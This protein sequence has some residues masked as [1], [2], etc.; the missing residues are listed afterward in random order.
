MDHKSSRS[1]HDGGDSLRVPPLQVDKIS[2]EL[3]K[4]ETWLAQENQ[5]LNS[6]I[7]VESLKNIVSN[8]E[9][10]ISILCGISHLI[11]T[12]AKSLTKCAQ[13]LGYPP[14]SII[15]EPS[16]SIYTTLSSIPTYDLPLMTTS[17]QV[18]TPLRVGLPRLSLPMSVP[19]TS[20][21]SSL[22]SYNVIH[23]TY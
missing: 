19:P 5:N 11:N 14:P 22:P 16:I 4:L 18:S 10:N 23:F 2:S 3:D 17:T 15:V 9:K 7:I 8:D 6:I 12:H 1:S 20:I 21:P 13:E